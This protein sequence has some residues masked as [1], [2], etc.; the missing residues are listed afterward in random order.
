MTTCANMDS[1]AARMAGLGA[2]IAAAVGSMT[3][4]VWL[5]FAGLGVTLVLV[6]SVIERYGR[7]AWHSTLDAWADVRDWK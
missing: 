5:L 1:N 6:S 3:V 7:R 2:L 4:N